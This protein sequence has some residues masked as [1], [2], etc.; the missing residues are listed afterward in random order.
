MNALRPNG[1][2]SITEGMVALAHDIPG[3][4]AL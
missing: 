3:L 2:W 4:L 1:L